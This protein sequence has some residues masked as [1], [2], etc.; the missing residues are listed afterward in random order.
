MWEFTA[1]AW[2]SGSAMP[3]SN[4]QFELTLFIHPRYQCRPEHLTDLA[5]RMR[6]P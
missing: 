3:A 2:T 1:T 5:L 4:P 6:I